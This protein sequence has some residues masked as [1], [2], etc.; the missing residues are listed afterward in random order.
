[1]P[2]QYLTLFILLLAFLTLG[3]LLIRRGKTGRQTK[4]SD[5]LADSEVIHDCLDL[6]EALQK[7]RGLGGL[8]DSAGINQRL[9][10]ARH[11][12]Q[13]F[14]HWPHSHPP[15]A[16]TDKWPALQRNPADFDAHCQLIEALL[17]LIEQLEDRLQRRRANFRGIGQAC[18]A[19]E[20]LARLRGLCVR[21]AR[22]RRCPSGLQMQLRFICQRL[23][24]H[25]PDQQILTLLTHLEQEL[26]DTRHIRLT[27]G[28]CFALLTPLI[29]ERLQAIRQ[30]HR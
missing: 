21:A 28:Q 2:Q 26:I 4:L 27:P 7:H 24:S 25:S 3:W 17:T 16:L 9:A 6:L 23:R 11:I 19:V 15:P 18:R 14:Q 22:N 20:D 12:D 13:L 10:I 1:M 29:D 30:E 5:D 8:Q